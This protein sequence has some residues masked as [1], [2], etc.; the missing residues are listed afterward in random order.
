M[1]LISATCL[2]NSAD[3]RDVYYIPTPFHDILPVNRETDREVETIRKPTAYKKTKNKSC[4]FE[5]T[6]SFFPTENDEK[7]GILVK[8]NDL[9]MFEISEAKKFKLKKLIY[10]CF[11]KDLEEDLVFKCD[12]EKKNRRRKS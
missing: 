4:D 6:G 2:R 8:G 9:L 7:R 12:Y 3:K 10:S 1:F 11:D 5:K